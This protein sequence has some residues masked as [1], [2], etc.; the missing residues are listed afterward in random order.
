MPT[1]QQ[2]QVRRGDVV[3][4]GPYFPGHSVYALAYDSRAGRQRIWAASSSM[5]WGSVL[6]HSDDFGASWTTPEVPT[7]QFPKGAK[8]LASIWQIC[9]GRADE[10]DVIYCGVEPAA[11]FESR[12][13]GK[14]FQLVE[15][16]WQHPHREQWQPGGGGLEMKRWLL[17]HE[18][19]WPA[20][21]Q[22]AL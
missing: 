15:G 5:H 21:R 9:P 3:V 11:L 8:A 18:R 12:D 6:N 2:I 7:V 1:T 17:R 20:Q 14:S 10:P 19:S 4:R 13:A 16:L 22:L